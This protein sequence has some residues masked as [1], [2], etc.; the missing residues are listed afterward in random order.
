MKKYIFVALSFTILL[1]GCGLTRQEIKSTQSFGT[2]TTQIGAFGEAEFVNIRNEIIEMN[3]H[4][5]AIDNTKTS[6]NLVLDKPT[7]IEPT[8]VRVSASKALMLYGELLVRLVT[9]D[10]SENL[11]KASTNLI[12]NTE[13]AIGSDFTE[14]QRNAISQLI[15]GLGSFWVDKK[16][17]DA[18]REI[19]PKFS[20]AVNDLADLLAKDFSIE[21]G[22]EGYLMAY[23]TTAQRLKTAAI[24]LVNSGSKYSVLERDRGVEA[25]VLAEK[26]IGNA[27]A[28][29]KKGKDAISALKKANTQLVNIVE[30]QEYSLDDIKDF[31]KK[32]KVLSSV[33]D[34]I[35][36]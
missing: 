29:N 11:Q 7:Y 17:A 31:G 28:L 20:D 5:I 26:A 30:N 27:K 4:L 8:A 33:Y 12:D 25:Y 16:K 1:T 2:A 34:V 19:I 15:V 21:P 9:E 14:D 3:T 32:I 22:A 10:R 24:K 6:K 36:N 35:T 13:A 18:A 23:K